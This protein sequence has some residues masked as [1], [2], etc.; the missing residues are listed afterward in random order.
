MSG[1]SP[2]TRRTLLSIEAQFQRNA[3]LLGDYDPR[4]LMWS[5]AGKNLRC[6]M[7][8]CK[9]SFDAEGLC[10]VKYPWLS[11]ERTRLESVKVWEELLG[12]SVPILDVSGN[13]FDLF[14]PGNVF[15]LF[16]SQSLY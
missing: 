10:G 3:S 15:S 4:A 16:L 6:V 2:A 9:E 11:D 5:D 8:K 7:M 12:K 13:H 1:H 14:S